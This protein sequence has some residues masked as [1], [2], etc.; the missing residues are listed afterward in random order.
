MDPET[1]RDD[2]G[3]AGNRLRL[4]I[5]SNLLGKDYVE[6]RHMNFKEQS[7]ISK[8]PSA[9]CNFQLCRSSIR[10]TSDFHACMHMSRVTSNEL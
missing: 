3:P 8:S 1:E 2:R 6:E 5:P 4:Q 7:M 10:S 9:A